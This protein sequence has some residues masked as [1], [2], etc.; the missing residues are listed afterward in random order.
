MWKERLGGGNN[1]LI[2]LKSPQMTEVQHI[3]APA[4]SQRPPGTGN[5][6]SRAWA[7]PAGR[8]ERS[9][10]EQGKA[11]EPRGSGNH[12]RGRIGGHLTGPSSADSP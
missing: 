5:R 7:G 8:E 4:V 3:K 6:A 11:P 2:A 1:D 9:R 12:P 10:V